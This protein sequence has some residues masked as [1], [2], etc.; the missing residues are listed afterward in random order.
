MSPIPFKQVGF[1]SEVSW[2]SENWFHCL[3]SGIVSCFLPTLKDKR[4]CFCFLIRAPSSIPVH[5]KS[6]AL[7]FK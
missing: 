7:I 6:Q 1:V 3:H 4:T 5:N 2:I